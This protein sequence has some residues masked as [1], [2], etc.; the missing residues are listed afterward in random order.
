MSCPRMYNHKDS[1]YS[2]KL[3]VSSL[4][5]NERSGIFRLVTLSYSKNA[6]ILS[7]DSTAKDEVISDLNGG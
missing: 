1:I 4:P 5:L 3:L 2:N 7:I 6:G